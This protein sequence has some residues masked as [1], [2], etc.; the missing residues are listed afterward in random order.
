MWGLIIGCTKLYILIK[1]RKSQKERNFV[2][3]DAL[4]ISFIYQLAAK[5][6]IVNVYERS[7]TT[8][9]PQANQ[10]L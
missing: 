9:D 7:T 3:V 1:K 6:L 4:I 8:S 2:S 10:I 5:L